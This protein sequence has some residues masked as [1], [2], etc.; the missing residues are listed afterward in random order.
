MKKI[1]I[2][3]RRSPRSFAVGIVEEE[4]FVHGPRKMVSVSGL[5]GGGKGRNFW[6]GL[7]CFRAKVFCV[8]DDEKGGF[9][10]TAQ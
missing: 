6:S 5:R 4:I 8:M 2:A 10:L 7:V 9:G 3:L 1:Q